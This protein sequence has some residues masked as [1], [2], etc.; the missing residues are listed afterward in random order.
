MPE[1]CSPSSADNENI[2]KAKETSVKEHEATKI[3]EIL[4]ALSDPTRLKIITA[5]SKKELCV[6]EI[7]LALNLSQSLVSHQLQALRLLDIVK[8]RKE[9]RN[10]HYS[11]NNDAA[12]R[13]IEE[14]E[15][16]L[17]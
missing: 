17:R 9:G 11:L 8:L 3:S 1:I 12:L 2:Q 4:K 13:I 5:I 7:A 10:M 16:L 15:K 14:C 6:C